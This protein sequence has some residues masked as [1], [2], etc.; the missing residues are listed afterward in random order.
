ML[1]NTGASCVLRK[2]NPSRVAGGFSKTPWTPPWGLSHKIP[3]VRVS[4]SLPRNAFVAASTSF[5]SRCV[6][7]RG[8]EKYRHS[9]LPR[10]CRMSGSASLTRGILWGSP[11]GGVHDVC[12]TT[13]PVRPEGLLTK[14][15]TCLL[16]WTAVHLPGNDEFF[17]GF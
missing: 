5:L 9:G 13:H 14:P 17:R 2:A 8:Q 7:V 3:L 1:E 4:K 11:Q 16:F 6:L 10:P 15:P 12:G